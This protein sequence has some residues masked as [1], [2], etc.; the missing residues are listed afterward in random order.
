MEK[1]SINSYKPGKIVC[2]GMNYRGHVSEQ[3]GRFPDKPVLFCKSNTSIIKNNENIICPEE[4]KELDYEVELAVVIGK[5]AK[6]VLP[7]NMSDYIYGYTIMNDVTARDIQKKEGQWFRAKSFDTF[8][9]IGPDIILAKYI[10][11]PDNINLKS[12]V[13][14]E[15]RQDSNTSDMIFGVY[16]LI[17]FI[18]KSMTL[19]E[20]D[21]VSTGTPAGVGA[22]RKQKSFLRNEDI[23]SCQIDNIGELVNKIVK[24]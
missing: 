24:E 9:P 21:L 20:G 12:Y 13:N 14:G 19:E 6:N 2:V 3:D 22:F 17:S 23:I 1:I 5:K 11:N 15:L 8:A 10:K 16:E 7:E 18:S 4:V